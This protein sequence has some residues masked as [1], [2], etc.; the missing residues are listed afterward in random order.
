M[1]TDLPIALSPKRGPGVC[2]SCGQVLA[3]GCRRYCSTACRQTLRQR[4]TMRTGLLKAINTRF[5]T[6]YFTK[7]VIVLDV[8]PHGSRQIHS[9]ILARSQGK[10]PGDDFSRMA[11]L[12]GNAWWQEKNRTRRHYLASRH[13]LEMARCRQEPLSAVRPNQI[14]TP[15][16][17]RQS[18]VLLMLDAKALTGPNVAQ[19]IKSAFRR[20][21]KHHHPDIGG[22]QG[23]FVRLHQA[24]EHLLDWAENPVFQNRR[25]FADK[26]F[27]DG[28]TNRWVQPAPLSEG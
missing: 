8:L 27:Y 18:L 4:L 23:D 3:K 17:R 10:T 14:R 20:A 1:T 28:N 21:A 5:A 24:Y 19:R 16:V 2:L 11:N 22:D 15:F 9:F 7:T 12:M 6:F 13:L 25:G 26:W